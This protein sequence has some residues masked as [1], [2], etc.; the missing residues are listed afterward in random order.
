MLCSNTEY[1]KEYGRQLDADQELEDHQQELRDSINPW[2]FALFKKKKALECLRLGETQF[3]S[4]SIAINLQEFSNNMPKQ[5]R[6]NKR[7]FVITC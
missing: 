3:M 6:T 1:E 4:D 5:T 7:S 2:D